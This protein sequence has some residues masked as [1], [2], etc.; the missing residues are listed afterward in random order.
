MNAAAKVKINGFDFDSYAPVQG[1]VIDAAKKAFATSVFYKSVGLL[2][3]VNVVLLGWFLAGWMG[4]MVHMM[5]H[6]F[7][8]GMMMLAEHGQFSG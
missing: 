6:K 4:L 1:E 7:A 3:A 5:L 2:L 8:A